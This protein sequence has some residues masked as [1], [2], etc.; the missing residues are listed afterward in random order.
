[1]K[2]E[3]NKGGMELEPGTWIDGRYKILRFLGKG[4]EG[5]VYLAFQEKLFRFYAIKEIAKE[6]LCFSRESV[7]VWKTL[8]CTG[9]PEIVDV[10][11]E[12]EWIWIVMEYVEGMNL[13][14]YLAEAV[15]LPVW[16]AAD[17][18]LQMIEVLE[19]LHRQNPPILYGDLKPDNIIL[20]KNRIVMVDM[21]SLIRQGSRGKRT[22]TRAY[23]APVRLEDQAEDNYSLGK[24]MESLAFRCKSSKM[25]RLSEKIMKQAQN[26]KPRISKS[27]KRA[28]KNLKRQ[29]SIEK[30]MLCITAMLLLFSGKASFRQIEH[31]NQETQ[32]TSRIAELRTMPVKKRKEQLLHLIADHPEEKEAYLELLRVY[33]EDLQMDQEEDHAYRKLWKEVPPDRTESYEEILKKNLEAYQEVA[34]ESGISYWYFYKGIQRKN[35]AASW[36]RKVT[37]MPEEVCKNK[38]LWEKS[39][40]YEQMCDYQEKWKH[41]DETGEK[42]GLFLAYWQD[43]GQLLEK[44]KDQ[45]SMVRLMLW[46]DTLAAWNHYMVE[47]REAEVTKEQMEQLLKQM[48]KE[49]EQVPE[50]HER[51]QEL[52]AQLEQEKQQTLQVMARVYQEGREKD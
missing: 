45:I 11:E 8:Q 48:E 5:S 44:E 7:E 52:K 21:G 17:W 30:G 14:D 16:Q 31:K 37:E 23:T 18:C 28:L 12:E 49:L 4:S 32:Y 41:Y 3:V 27:I 43:L 51:M 9:L 20:R 36:F 47:L 35:Y 26:G 42:E 29:R 19:Y 50:G 15:V 10:C 13:Q 46:K 34:Y 39:S 38:D 6:G 1:M 2:V 24:L 40:L 25:K 33:Q 22:G